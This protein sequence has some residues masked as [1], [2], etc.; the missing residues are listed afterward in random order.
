MSLSLRNQFLLFGVL[1]ERK[2]HTC[3]YDMQQLNMQA[4]REQ[5]N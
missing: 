5:C 4:A 2:R 1:Q 3:F